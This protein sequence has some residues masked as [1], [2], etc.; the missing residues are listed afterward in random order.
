MLSAVAAP[1]VLTIP[2]I[3]I[4]RRGLGRATIT[5]PVMTAAGPGGRQR[6]AWFGTVHQ[7]IKR[8]SGISVPGLI[9]A[10]AKVWCED[11]E[12]VIVPDGTS[13]SQRRRRLEF[14]GPPA[15]PSG[16]LS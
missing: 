4:A 14:S 11:P 7:S 13:L 5:I 15:L 2:K 6:L 9:R 16:G 10:P 12:S 3:P 8:R 1:P